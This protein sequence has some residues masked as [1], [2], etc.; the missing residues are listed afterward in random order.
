MANSNTV[1]LKTIYAREFQRSH[2]KQAVYPMFGDVRFQAALKDGSTVSWDYDSD[3]APGSLGDDDAY[4][5]EAKTITAE[6]LTVNQKPAHGFIIPGTQK[7]QDHR[8]TQEK[9]AKKSL[10]IIT[11]KIDGD[12][13]KDLRDGAV[14]TLDNASFGGSASDPVTASTS[15]V[16]NIFAAA[17]RILKNQNIIYN[18]N[19][20]FQNNVKLDGGD[21]MP[22][23]A[24]P[25]E[26][27]EQ[28]DLAVG[29]KDTG[30]GDATLKEGFK[31]KMFGFNVVTS[32]SLPFS[33]RLVQT[34]TP[35]N[36]KFLVLGALTIN[37]VTTI[38]SA[39][40]NVLAETNATASVTNLAAFLNDIFEGTA[41]AKYVGF[42][43]TALTAPEKRISDNVSAVDGLD[44]S[45]VITIAG[46]GHVTVT[47][48]ESGSVIDREMVHAIF[49]VSQSIGMVMQRTPEIETS[50][51]NLITAT[52]LTGNVGKQYLAW[53]LYGRK[54]FKTQTYGLVNVKVASTSFTSPNSIVL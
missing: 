44:G 39:V 19:K 35:T 15:N 22:L 20:V 48:D 37:W 42:T 10:N 23:C 30:M 16:L 52:S 4:T 3:A 9:W 46:Q 33:L 13:L 29:A 47:T 34:G 11:T 43:R 2:Y 26:L 54:V 38:G 12:V 51:G 28:L 32:N 6:T 49:G 50:P 40:G 21:R 1:P 41:S 36:G 17:K 14:S 5:L 53:G 45:I 18:S 7:I 31:G 8:P 24:I 27:E 25:A